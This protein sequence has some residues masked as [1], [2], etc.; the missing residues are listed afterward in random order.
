MTAIGPGVKHYSTST[1]VVL[2]GDPTVEDTIAGVAIKT[3]E[4]SWTL[5][6]A[7]R[8]QIAIGE[9]LTIEHKGAPL[10][11]AALISSPAKGD[12]L[13]IT[14]ADNT[15]TK[16]TGGGKVPFGK[17]TSVAGD[18]RGTPTGYVVV[19]LDARDSI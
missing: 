15:L 7:N 4:Q 12:P 16:T 13:W 6:L 14:I 5:G 8:N 3:T 9:P 19:D 17:I 18:N 10:V 2:H 11:R 1:K